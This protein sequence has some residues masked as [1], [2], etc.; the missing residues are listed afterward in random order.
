MPGIWGMGITKMIIKN[1]KTL[2]CERKKTNVNEGL[3][4]DKNVQ[5]SDTRMLNKEQKRVTKKFT[6]RT[7][8]D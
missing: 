5:E 6:T 2:A 3:N 1:I 7:T 4:K 8:N